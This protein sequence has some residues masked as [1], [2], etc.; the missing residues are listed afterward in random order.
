MA[1]T[2]TATAAAEATLTTVENAKNFWDKYSKPI[3]YVVGA[4]AVLTVA[5]YAYKNYVVEPQKIEANEAFFAAEGLF[6][7]MASTG[8]NKDSINIVMNGGEIDGQ[9]V[10]G[11]L[12]V[13]SNFGSTPAGD[14]AEYIAGACYL[15]LKEFDKAIK[16]LEAFDGNGATQVQSKAYIMLGHAYAEKKKNSEALSNYKKAASVNE[17]DDF[18]APDAL[19]M[20]AAFAASTG[21]SKEAISLYQQVKEKYPSNTA[22]ISGDVD[23]NLARLGVLN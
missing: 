3:L 10:T 1:E 15:H 16:H 8:F 13:I 6:A 22:V 5:W 23:K 18:F 20:A 14:R 4:V 11:A 9:K 19:L 17:K 12:K 2:K 21:D 7:K